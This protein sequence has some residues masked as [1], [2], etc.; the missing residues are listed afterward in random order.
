MAQYEQMH[1]KTILAHT[2]ENVLCDNF[3]SLNAYIF[4]SKSFPHTFAM[5]QMILI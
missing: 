4:V 2:I 1:L 5:E 3:F